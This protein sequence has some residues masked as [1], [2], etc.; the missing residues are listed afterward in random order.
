MASTAAPYSPFAGGKSGGRKLTPFEDAL[1][2]SDSSI[3][4]TM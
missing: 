3:A 1:S 2:F 4:F